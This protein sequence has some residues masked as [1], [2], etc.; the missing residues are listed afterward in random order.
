[1]IKNL[2]FIFT[3]FLILG[4]KPVSAMEEPEEAVEREEKFNKF[5]HVLLDPSQVKGD[6]DFENYY[7]GIVW[8]VKKDV[9]PTQVKV[10][11]FLQGGRE[12]KPFKKIYPVKYIIPAVRSYGNY[13]IGKNFNYGFNVRSYGLTA[14][15]K[16]V[17][18]NGII[19]TN[20][21]YIRYCDTKNLKSISPEI[22]FL[23]QLRKGGKFWIIN[24]EQQFRAQMLFENGNISFIGKKGYEEITNIKNIIIP[25][26]PRLKKDEI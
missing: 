21:P 18:N 12:T 14:K 1:M 20:E 9:G 17:F 5:Q 2:C 23:K 19:R 3:L 25:S 22:N 8:A 10:K 4:F 7:E 13:R 6:K 15:I 24:E 11:I 16:A 26:K